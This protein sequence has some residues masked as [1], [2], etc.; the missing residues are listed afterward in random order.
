VQCSHWLWPQRAERI[1]GV[2]AVLIVLLASLTL[3]PSLTQATRAALGSHGIPGA[4]NDHLN[5][6]R[7]RHALLEC[8]LPVYDLKIE[9]AEY[10]RIL[11]VVEEA[12]QRGKL[13][14]DLKQW[15][16][17]KFVYQGATRKV[18]IR[19]RG[20]GAD[21]WAHQ[22]RSWRIRFP[23]DAPLD[24]RR[25]I[26]LIVSS[27]G[28]AITERFTNA[29]FHRLGLLTLRDGYAVLR[30]N[31]IPQGVY[32]EVEHWDAPL[33]AYQNRPA[34]T[35]FRNPGGGR[36]L[37]SFE[38]QVAKDDPAAWT[39]LQLL[40]NY[41]IHP[42]AE[43]FQA[44]LAVT[45]LDDYLRFVAGTTLFC[46]DHTSMVTD[47]HRLYFDNSLGRF[48]R[49]PWDLEPQR[50]PTIERF[51]LADW[52]ATFDV[53]ARWPMSNFRV[54]VLRDE[55]LRLRRDRI[56]WELVQDDSLLKLFDHVY[57]DL[58][59]AFWSDVMGQGDEENRLA[60]FRNLVAHNLKLIAKSLANSRM[61]VT[62]RE[63]RRELLRLEFA[64]NN[65]A[66]T[67]LL[68]IHL[69]DQAA[70]TRC[71]LYGDTDDLEA[72]GTPEKLL[73]SGEANSFG[74]VV[75]Q[76]ENTVLP[77]GTGVAEDYP[78]YVYQSAPSA[79]RYK[80]EP[81]RTVIYPET[82]RFTFLLTRAAPVAGELPAWSEVKIEA[83]NAVTGHLLAPED[84]HMRI[85]RDASSADFLARMGNR[86][87]FLAANPMFVAPAAGQ[88]AQSVVL[89]ARTHQVE[90]TIVV[91][92][93]VTL[94]LMPGARLE[95][96]PDANLVCFGPILAEGRED[97]PIRI[98]PADDR[99][100]GTLAAVD[101]GAEC[102]FRHVEVG[103]GGGSLQGVTANGISLT[104]AIAIHR[105]D[106]IFEHCRF[107]ECPGEDALNVKNGRA[108]IRNSFFLENH[109]DGLDLDFVEG[110]VT[111]C[112]FVGNRGDAL[113][114]C[115]SHVD[116]GHCR[117]EK[118]GDKGISTGERSHVRIR[119]TMVLDNQTGIAVKDSSEVRIEHCTL[120]GN[121]TAV[122]AY[123]KKPIFGGGRAWLNES[124]LV[125]NETTAT[126]DAVS[127]IEFSDCTGNPPVPI[128]GITTV[129]DQ[130]SALRL[131]R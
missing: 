82:R 129:A 73:A 54:A 84:L 75:L 9:P 98:V 51:D 37:G 65:T 53:F 72:V 71:C 39:A 20:D 119:Q 105:G 32:Y 62:I 15:S 6:F 61:D 24:G 114:L 96:R 18:K 131:G 93:G 66:G 42:T 29:V 110:E 13:T 128:A 77:P 28:K 91:P 106:A 125:D 112:H 115:G 127:Q 130:A 86:D 26:N 88:S 68:R 107:S 41:E 57:R 80:T 23:K 89:E 48:L 16:Q 49:I 40:L 56:L 60:T 38:E 79:Q 25:E 35:I 87:A 22:R 85:L 100:W 69:R 14:D 59:F 11:Q 50:I 121:A 10:R 30:I 5:P 124:S 1:I 55:H 99:P 103:G 117:M 36:D 45:D 122:T 46:A 34:T 113:D 17:A 2:S 97:A 109:S 70:G 126:S 95:M 44:A 102:R 116:V 31:G 104:G 76:L 123:C 83:A 52:H 90:G 108:T 63:V 47:N 118:S 74:Q 101:P 8:G 33:L 67:V 111:S 12:K 64:V 81:L 3:A 43:N 94:V 58:G 92:H 19:V 78:A 7:T 120:T 21:H 4:A 27:D